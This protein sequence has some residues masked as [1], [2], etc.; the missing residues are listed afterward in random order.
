MYLGEKNAES[1]KHIILNLA[2]GTTAAKARQ[3]PNGLDGHRW[4]RTHLRVRVRVSA[5][6]RYGQC[7]E[8]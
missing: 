2:R 7:T 1:A 3:S 4:F 6:L 5:S 8:T